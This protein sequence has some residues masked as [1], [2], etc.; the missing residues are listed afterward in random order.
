MHST[1]GII[2]KERKLINVEKGE[3][4]NRQHKAHHLDPRSTT[5]GHRTGKSRAEDRFLCNGS[6][7]HGQQNQLQRI[8]SNKLHNKG[9]IACILYLATHKRKHKLNDNVRHNR[10]EI[11]GDRQPN[12]NRLEFLEEVL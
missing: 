2:S 5:C 3:E 7:E 12:V 8:L 9:V 1:G 11:A 10:T 4:E 6:N